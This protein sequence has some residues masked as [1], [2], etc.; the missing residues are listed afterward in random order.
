MEESAQPESWCICTYLLSFLNLSSIINLIILWFVVKKAYGWAKYFIVS[1]QTITK[2]K[3]ARL[4]RDT[5]IYEFKAENKEVLSWKTIQDLLKG[6]FEGRFTCR[7]IITTY[8]K[9]SYTIGRG[10][11]LS[12]DEMF[13]YALEE[14]DK[15]DK[16]LQEWLNR[17]GNPYKELG[18][19]HGKYN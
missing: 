3:D 11:E 19:L 13:D 5:K 18:K 1:K 10:L 15:R 8:V 16:E 12:A 2:A 6:Q 7:D 4:K 17:K 9:R 14:A